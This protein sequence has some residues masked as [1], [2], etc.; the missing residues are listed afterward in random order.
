MFII[1]KK[2]MFLKYKEFLKIEKKKIIS[3]NIGWR[4]E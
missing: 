2:F 1:E 4:N 3:R